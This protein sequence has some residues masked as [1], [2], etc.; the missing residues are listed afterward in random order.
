MDSGFKLKAAYQA[1]ETS[2][3]STP[4]ASSSSSLFSWQPSAAW[5]PVAALCGALLTLAVVSLS[6]GGSI[7]WRGTRENHL[8]HAIGLQAGRLAAAAPP[9]AGPAAA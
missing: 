5:L 2:P 1:V 7:R 3:R 6:G 4:R 9:A 8:Q